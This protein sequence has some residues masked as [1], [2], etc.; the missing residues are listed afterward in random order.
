M[1]DEKETHFDLDLNISKL[2]C[3]NFHKNFTV[4]YYNIFKIINTI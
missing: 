4:H 3:S 1:N 2:K